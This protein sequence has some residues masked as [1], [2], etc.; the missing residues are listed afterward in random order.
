MDAIFD[1]E[2]R[3]RLPIAA[4]HWRRDV[5]VCEPWLGRRESC[6]RGIC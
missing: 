4:E 2:L 1:E 6:E 5:H 3:A